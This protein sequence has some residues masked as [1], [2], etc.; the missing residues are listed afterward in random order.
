VREQ[1]Q[2]GWAIEFEDGLYVFGELELSR[3]MMSPRIYNDNE[4]RQLVLCKIRDVLVFRF[5]LLRSNNPSVPADKLRLLRWHLNSCFVDTP[6]ACELAVAA[7]TKARLPPTSCLP[8]FYVYLLGVMDACCK[9]YPWADQARDVFRA[10]VCTT[11]MDGDGSQ[12]AFGDPLM[13]LL[14]CLVD[15]TNQTPTQQQLWEKFRMCIVPW[16]IECPHHPGLS[17]RRGVAKS[18]CVHLPWQRQVFDESLPTSYNSIQEGLVHQWCS[19]HSES[20]VCSVCGA[21]HFKCYDLANLC[22][23]EVLMV[24]LTNGPGSMLVNTH[25]VLGQDEYTLTSA[26]YYINA[27]HWAAQIKWQDTWTIYNYQTKRGGEFNRVW[28]A[29]EL[30]LLWYTRTTTTGPGPHLRFTNT[31]LASAKPSSKCIIDLVD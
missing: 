4:V 22:L 1:R 31:F 9:D 14:A 19:G 16:Y 28:H 7:V 17:S 26:A 30:S 21:A 11:R 27:N 29:K 15:N 23:P 3:Y 13:L 2:T 5:C 12:G 8:F 24:K 25:L 20:T 18:L 10:E 6:G